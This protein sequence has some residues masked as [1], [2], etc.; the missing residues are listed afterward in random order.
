MFL[1]GHILNI[2]TKL[3][4]HLVTL[5]RNILL[6]IGVGGRAWVTEREVGERERKSVSVRER[7]RE[8]EREK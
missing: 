2:L 6:Q 8:R 1:H 7:E 3:C 4:S 5:I